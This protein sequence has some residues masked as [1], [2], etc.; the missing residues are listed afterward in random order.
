MFARYRC[1]WCSSYYRQDKKLSGFKYATISGTTWSL[2]AVEQPEEKTPLIAKG[3]DMV[4]EIEDNYN[5]GLLSEEEKHVK[6]IEVWQIIRKEI[7]DILEQRLKGTRN[8]V[9]DLITS[10]ARGQIIAV[11]SA[12]RYE[13]YYGEQLG[14]TTKFLLLVLT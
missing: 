12:C 3:W 10:G 11:D 5:E 4:G 7:Q 8:S 13:G 9:S 14:R 2:T 6:T 1:C